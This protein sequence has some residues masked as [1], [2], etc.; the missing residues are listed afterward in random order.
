M[1]DD[2]EIPPSPLHRFVRG[3][4]VVAMSHAIGNPPLI[5]EDKPSAADA[6]SGAKDQTIESIRGLSIVLL[7]VYHSVGQQEK[8]Q[9][10]LSWAF[11]MIDPIVMPLFAFMAGYVYAMRPATW[12]GIPKA[13]RSK[14]RRILIPFII[15][16]VISYVLKGLLDGH[17]A[18][19]E[20]WKPLLFSYEHFWFLQSLFVIFIVVAVADA[21]ELF[22]GAR[23]WAVATLAL[24]VICPLLPGPEF[25]SLWGVNYLLPM[26]AVGYGAYRY[27]SLVMSRPALIGWSVV[28][29]VTLTLFVSTK[30]D[31]LSIPDTRADLA[32]MLLGVSL[33]II[34]L[35]S[36]LET[37][38]LVFLGF[39]S[40]CIYLYHGFGIS[41]AVR[42]LG[43]AGIGE[44]GYDIYTAK[45][46]LG[47]LCPIALAL[48]LDR[49]K[50]ARR[51][52][53]GQS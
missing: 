39:T 44:G 15:V 49:I 5:G 37:R 53:L 45:V 17:V 19:R 30:L 13:I 24:W 35:A 42:L 33:S 29:A 3:G 11:E 2:G 43:A 31:V 32:P 7:V 52:V 47:L 46:A 9:A 50:W 10:P 27:T 41:L 20:L 23:R 38:A 25:F 4:I 8:A 51:L 26:F 22:G 18:W 1:E 21:L 28:G 48:V 12:A 40:Y 14:V 36:R 34:L 16:S 6:S